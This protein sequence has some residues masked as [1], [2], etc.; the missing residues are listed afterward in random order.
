MSRPRKSPERY[1][2]TSAKMNWQRAAE[3]RE[4]SSNPSPKTPRKVDREEDRLRRPSYRDDFSIS[5]LGLLFH[6]L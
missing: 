1:E 5:Y 3:Q 2:D 6:Y 4:K